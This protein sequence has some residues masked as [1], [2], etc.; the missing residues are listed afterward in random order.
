MDNFFIRVLMMK[1]HTIEVDE[2]IMNYLK[3]KADPFVDT[4]NTVLHKLLFGNNKIHKEPSPLIYN[5]FKSIPKALSQILE[6]IEEVVK[7][8]FSRPEATTIVANRNDTA[9]QTI[10]DKYCRQLGK[11]AIEVDMLLSEPK[12]EGFRTILTKKFSNHID[13]ITTFFDDLN[14]GEENMNQQKNYYHRPVE[15]I[16]KKESDR[17]KRDTALES[18]LKNALGEQL[19]DKFG[20]FTMERQ[21]RLIF[22][23]S[24]ML[25]KFSSFHDDQSKWFWGVR[26]AFWQNWELNDYLA[27]IMENKDRGGYSFIILDSDEAKKLFNTCSESDGEKKINMRIYAG[28]NVIRFQ[29]WKEFDIETRSKSLYGIPKD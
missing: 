3:K 28:D 17:K 7:N 18:A 19:K 13:V 20:S 25:C 10:M 16:P 24:R 22:N 4:P 8:E 12:L 6:V 2:I 23:D 5:S 14:K 27:L 26:K 9:L 15:E 11:T 1:Q 21:S 29:N